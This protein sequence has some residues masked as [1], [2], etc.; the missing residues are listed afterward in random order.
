MKPLSGRLIVASPQLQDPNFAKTVVMMLRHEAEGALGVVLNR[1]GDKTV[2]DVWE[3]I[4]KQPCGCDQFVHV[5]GPVPGPLIA[6]HDQQPLGESRVL[7]GLFMSMQKDPIEQLVQTPG[8][9]F[10]LYSGHAGWGGGQLESEM[11]AGGW[12][13]SDA[14]QGDVFSDVE[15]LWDRVCNR[16]GRKIVAPKIRPEQIP[17]DPSLN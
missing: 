10:R 8:A 16:I 12:L 17:P 2:D 15:T 7:P 6:L 5:G 4:D 3:M 11:E 13:I 14:E 1:P 9:E